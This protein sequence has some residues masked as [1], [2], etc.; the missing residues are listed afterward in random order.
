MEYKLKDL[1]D[2]PRMREV[3]DTFDAINSMPSAI[4]DIDGNVLI[5]NSWQDI[6]T[7]FH[8]VN[9]ES[10]KKCI[11]SDTH[12]VVELEKRTPHVIY[13]CPMGL[14][15]SASPIIIDGKHLGNV[16]TGQLFLEPPDEAK[17]IEQAR[18]YGFDEAEYLAA[19]RKVPL[20]TEEQLHKNLTFIHTLAVMTTE[21]ALQQKRAL[22]ASE[23]LRKSDERHR[24]ILQTTLDGVWMVDMHGR[25]LEV[26]ESYAR[27]SGYSVQELLTLHV[28]DLDV[29]ET[30][31]DTIV[32]I[33]AIKQH[34]TLLFEARHRRKD[35]SIFDV[36]T[37]VQYRSEDGGQIVAFI[38]DVTERKQAEQALRESENEFRFLAEA[39]PQIVWITRA[40]GWNIYFNQ[41]WMEYTGLTPEESHGHGWNKPFHSDDQQRAWDAW[42]NAVNNV[43]TYSLE[44]RLRRADGVYKWWLIRG[45]P[46]LDAEGTILKW[47]GTCTDIDEFKK[48]EEELGKREATFRAVA[49]LSPMAIY[50]SSG[51]DQKGVY[52]NEA[53]F[54]TFGFSMEDIPTV[55]LWWIKAF[56]DEKYR[57]QVID[58]WT[59]NIV[60]ANKNNT[61]VEALECVCV[62][63]DGSE[64]NIA[65][66]GKTIGDEFWAF[67]YDLTERKQAEVEKSKLEAQ[68]NQAQ[69][70]ESVGRLAGGVAHDFNNM[71]TVIL[72]HAQLGLMHLE[73]THPVCANLAEISKTAERSADLTRQLLAFARKQTIAP[74]VLDL[75]ETISGMLKMM[76]R[77]IGED[78]NLNWHPA[79]NLWP[80]KMDPSQVDQILANLCVNARDSIA[81]VGKINIE[82]GSS[83]IDKEYCTQ[84]SGCMVGEYVRLSLSDNGCGMDK[85]TQEQIFEPFFTTK[86]IG[87]GTGLGLATV[88]GIVKQ[89]NGFINVYSEPGLG[90]TFTIYLPRY[91]GKAEQVRTEGTVE[92]AKRGKETILLVEDE[93]II[94]NI[95]SMILTKQGYTI[96]AAHTPSEAIRLASENIDKIQILITDVVMPEMNGKDLAEKLQSLY[97]QLKCLYMSGYTSDVIAHHGVLDEGVYFI[98]KPYS[99]LDLASKVRAV[100][101]GT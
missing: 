20:F 62:C 45:V 54:K 46:V 65:W 9:P 22:E 100:L 41:Q 52:A 99:L 24:S 66:V 74:K 43:G 95:T 57:Q 63:K 78:I 32:H 79:P 90:T 61:D 85:A 70:L 53:F 13:K 60:Q 75:N 82:T 38:R 94:L 44:C 36:E 80:V 77:L 15:D 101:D 23:Q 18:Q 49:E 50:A 28:Y 35:G 29:D 2:I 4:I 84:N 3:F 56:P 21:Q 55:G 5:A 68:L 86:G 10:E 71:L 59:Y 16:F 7:K 87:E 73:P 72:G 27:M 30:P 14:V 34:G 76:Q 25:V 93:P 19:M 17:F 11:E 31:E 64:K 67:G 33:E 69:K 47:F 96:L 81:N 37:N 88:Y 40:D 98:Q 58:Q 48:A 6:C 97:P 39:M 42:Q 12:F 83:I 92:P 91:V 89:N 1:I 8:R 26:N 51:S